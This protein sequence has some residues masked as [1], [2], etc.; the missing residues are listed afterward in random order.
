MKNLLLS[1]GLLFT[2]IGFSQP[3]T[4]STSSYTVPQLVNN[5]LI[6]SPCV[7]ATNITWRTGTDFGSSNGIGF[8]QNTNSSLPM[9]SGVILS[10]GNIVNA[11]G[12]NTSLLNDGSPAWTGDASLEATM[13]LAGIPMVSKNASVLEFD[14]MPISPNFS[15][16]FVFASE[17]YGNF[18]CQYSDAFAFLLTNLNTGVTTNLAVV[19]NTNTPISVVTIRDFLYNSSCPSINPQYFGSFNGG[20]NAAN[21]AINFNGQTQV[22]TAASV[23][24]PGVAYHIKLVI[25]DRA[26]PQSDSSIFISSDS[27]NIGQDVLGLDLTLANN[28]ALCYGASHTINTGLNTT[29]YSFVWKKDGTTLSTETGATLAINQAGTYSVTYTNLFSN[30]QP[31]TDSVVIEYYPEITSPNPNTIYRCDS[32][33]STYTFNLDLN[34]PVVKQGLNPATSVT[35][36][37]SQSNADN[38]VS[39]L[40]LLYNSASGQTVYVRIQLPN[41]P[42]FI[43]KSF[44]LS[45]SPGPIANQPQNLV[46][47]ARST[48]NNARFDLTQQNTVILNGQS[49]S[50]N[51]IT[52]YTSLNDANNAINP[53]TNP[54][55]YTSGNQ[56]IYVRVQNVSDPACFSVTSFDLI[57]NPLPIVDVL[58]N[59]L[60]CTDYVLPTITNGN[61]FTALNGTGT[62]LFAGNVISVTQTIFIFNQPGG[63]TSCGANSSFNV[64]IVD[65]NSL[66]PPS[67]NSCGNYTLPSLSYG[68]YHTAPA[69]GGTIIPAGTVISASQLIYFYFTTTTTPV[70][71]VDSSFNVTILQ[72]LNVGSRPDV[73][74]CTSYTLPALTLGNY[75]AQPGGTGTQIPAGTVISSNQTV[76]VY[77]SS[78]G[79]TS[80]TAEDSFEVFIGT[81]PPPDVTQCNGY[82]LPQLA[83]GNYYSAPAGTGQLIPSGTVIN[84]SAVIYIYI[85]TSGNSTSNCTDN[86]H[87]TLDISQPPVDTLTDQSVCESYTLPQL[88]NGE[89]FT[90]I[91]GT[92]TQLYPGDV[93][94]TTQTIYIRKVLNVTC[95]NQTSFTVTIL[96]LPQIDSRSDIDICDQYVLTA[97]TV[98]DYYTGPNGT[99]TML[100]AGTVITS[101]QLIYIYAVSSGPPA[102]SSQNTFQ[103]NIFSTQ[104]DTLP[105]NTVCDSYTLPTLTPNNRYYTLS[106][107]PNGGGIELLPGDVITTSQTIYIFKESIIRT[108]FSCTNETSFTLTINQTP[109][110]APIA[111]VNEC[112]SYILPALAVGNYFTGTNGSGTSLSA[113]DVITTDQTIYVFA[114]T[115]T[116]PN[117]SS[118]ISFT[119]TLFN[120]D[121][122]PDITICENYTLQTLS[123]G[124]YYTGPNRTGSLLGAG[125]M[126]STS[127][128]I[129]IHGQSP[130]S[131]CSDESS[132]T[133]TIIDTP[134]ANP[135]AVALRT[136]CDEDGTNDGIF[137]FDLSNL[138]ATI[139]GSQTGSEFSVTYHENIADAST[140]TNPVTSSTD[141]TLFARVS[142]TLAP[143]CFDIEQIDIIVNKLPEPTPADGIVCI[144][145]E[146]GTLLNS[147]TMYSGLNSATTKF[148]WTDAAGTIVGTGNSYTA[149]LP[150]V[151]TLVATTIATGC[152]SAPV[153]VTVNQS[154]PAVVTYTVSEDFAAH[155]TITVIAT[156]VGGDYEYQLDAGS[157]QDSPVFENVNSGIHTVTVRDKNGCGYAT[158]EALVLNYPK[159][160][161]PNGDGYNDTWNI[162]DL[163][164]QPTASITIFDRFGKILRQIK[165]NTEGWDGT[166]NGHIMTSDDYWFS[167]SY[168][169]ENLINR[170]FKSHFAMKR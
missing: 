10:T 100:T 104:A 117:C 36:F 62:P 33:A 32:G 85:P 89:Y 91:D 48:Q 127:Q 58:P 169:D 14:F 101:S 150:G 50:I 154:E 11:P 151:Y 102:C 73:F 125:T 133:I 111:N 163:S 136:V 61:Y 27:F 47:C 22:L 72:T 66:T 167:V 2:T 28:N 88:T 165:P 114:Q 115:N 78:T 59:V 57:V 170:E 122:I 13:A 12:P 52:Y 19:P 37:A 29:N 68:E 97:L 160:F 130:Y 18:Q 41:S 15:F 24:T 51:I 112:N 16:D 7:S 45:T 119:V 164:N 31:I 26:D 144:D 30:C 75:F 39:P 40:P 134:V 81:T 67:V 86:L 157:Y 118:E 34:T 131:I 69:G 35:Y 108:S 42:C 168:V 23:L 149:I 123:I 44:Q 103:I 46:K 95:A 4:V 132:F 92:G 146:T 93:I 141:T 80:C 105:N 38:N 43:V 129:Y 1:I 96:G 71:V 56:T 60:V 17:E 159:F 162:T 110:I 98:G 142:N 145:S 6:N 83:I 20:S 107:G 135:V 155:Q 76:Y 148:E 158:S 25:A 94:I 166:Y 63:P 79:P 84:T 77:A 106:G 82:T 55:Q 138:T 161:T 9:Q 64:V 3:I 5:V 90:G 49:S 8:F 99:G 137:V 143:N 124:K 153:A 53:I 113:G 121:E 21:S 156:G 126:I 54:T 147:F 152:A 120:V 140:A 87:F 116:T 139:L 65:A 74:D 109:V 70:C 128:T